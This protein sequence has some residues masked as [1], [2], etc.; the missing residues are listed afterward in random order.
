VTSRAPRGDASTYE[1]ISLVCSTGE[2]G[3][4]VTLHAGDVVVQNGT[5]HR[6]LDQGDTAARILAVTIGARNSLPSGPD[7]SSSVPMPMSS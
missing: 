6:W 5:H 2:I 7:A 1:T 4:I 3:V